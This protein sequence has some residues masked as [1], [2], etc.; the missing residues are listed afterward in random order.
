MPFGASVMGAGGIMSR[1]ASGY[2]PL[3]IQTRDRELQMMISAWIN[4]VLAPAGLQLQRARRPRRNSSGTSNSPFYNPTSSC[5]IPELATL[6]D[7]FLGKKRDGLFVEVGAYD[8]ISFSNSS[9]LADAGW[10]GILIEPIPAFAQA[11]RDRYHANSRIRIV[12]TAVGATEGTV[13]ITLAGS[14]TTTNDNLLNEYR[15]IDWANAAIGATSR[16]TVP[17][18]TLDEILDAEGLQK[19]IDVLIVDVE[20]AEASVFA[21]FSISRWKPTMIIAELTHTHPDLHVIS[22]GDAHLQSAIQKAGYSVVYKDA[23]NTVF[24]RASAV[25][26]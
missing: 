16:L 1:A 7:L 12:E 3:P 19:P 9:C 14:L 17:Q 8:G 11:C 24:A 4:A 2:V 23:I 15:N 21:G 10:S 13:D 22:A 18:R 26:R 6:Y 5:Q 20:G 25:Q